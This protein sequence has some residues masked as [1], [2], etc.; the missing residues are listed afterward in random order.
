MKRNISILFSAAAFLAVCSC[1]KENVGSVTAEPSDVDA[2]PAKELVFSATFPELIGTKTEI[3][4]L[5]QVSWKAGDRISLYYLDAGT[6]ATAV[7]TAQDSGKKVRFTAVVP[8]GVPYFYAA[9]PEGIGTLSAQ[10]EFTIDVAGTTDGSFAAANYSA[11]YAAAGDNI[12][13]SF[14]N[15]V[16]LIRVKL[17]DGAAVAKGTGSRVIDAVSICGKTE[18]LNCLGR[19]SVIPSDGDVCFSEPAEPSATSTVVLSDAVKSSEYA[20]IPCLPFKASNGIAVR[21]SSADGPIPALASVDSK[22]VILVRSHIKQINDLGGNIV[23]D[24]YFS[25]DGTGDG[26]T[27][28]AP[29]GVDAFQK[30]L[31]DAQQPY[32]CWRLDGAVLHLADGTY[33]LT[34]PV[35]VNAGESGGII[36]EG[37][38]KGATVID[39]SGIASNKMF[40]FN[41]SMD[42]TFRNLTICNG[43]SSSN[44]G[45][46]NLAAGSASRFT[47]ENVKFS[48][49][50]STN[51]NSGAIYIGNA[52][53]TTITDCDFE[54]NTAKNQGGAFSIAGAAGN[55]NVSGTRFYKNKVTGTSTNSGGAIYDAGPGLLTVVNSVFDSNSCNTQGGAIKVDN[56][57]GRLFACGSFFRNNSIAKSGYGDNGGSVYSAN[58]KGAVGCYNCTFHYN[59]TSAASSSSSAFSAE[60]YVVANCT[61]V[62][63]VKVSYGVISNRASEDNVSTVVNSILLTTSTTATHPSLSMSAN[64][65]YN[66][67]SSSFNVLTRIQDNFTS[68]SSDATS[69]LDCTKAALGL[70][71]SDENIPYMAWDG[72]TGLDGFTKC[73]LQNVETAIRSNTVIGQDFWTWLVSIG[74]TDKDVRGVTRNTGAM[75]PGSYQQD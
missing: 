8:E 25:A 18:T 27:A 34:A 42:I 26:K 60:K 45:A 57:S 16:G 29:A 39:G 13:F 11:A 61:M 55:V 4:E 14:K 64:A 58:G 9:Y 48:G 53:Q 56:A 69:I 6:P 23:W 68:A 54:Q 47:L 38:S 37:A 43:S 73:T 62:E 49:N 52:G 12:M 46:V 70:S 59:H 21:F 2:T 65:A 17:P 20:Y 63:S 15:A 40:T 36:I 35:S 74:A 67:L 66:H 50:S 1:A 44:G 32:G 41:T 31:N 51:G 24:W 22:E 7:A 19:V 5:G 3:D 75:W 28:S 71:D 72:T 10:G 30:L 33:S